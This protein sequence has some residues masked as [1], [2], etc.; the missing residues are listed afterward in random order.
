MSVFI[1]IFFLLV[2]FALLGISADYVV[3]N[4][5]Y[6]AT[7]LKIRLFAFGILLG[8]VTSLP[9]LSVG[10]NTTLDRAT[11]LSVGNLLGGMII[12][13]SLVV[14]CS[15]LLNRKVVTDG[16]LKI[17]IPQ[18]A[19]IFSPIL[20]GLDGTYGLADGLI[21]IGLYF[22]LIYYLFRANYS[23]GG[24]GFALIEK[25]KIIKAI[26]LSVVGAVGVLLLSHWIV[27]RSL[28]LSQDWGIS[29]LLL[30]VL[31]FS[32]GTNLPEISIAI[33]SWRKHISELSLSHLLSSTFTNV[34]ILGILAFIRPITIVVGPVYY[35][36]AIFLTLVLTLFLFFYR[37]GKKMDR[38]KG[39]FY[40]LATYYF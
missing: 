13:L 36:L 40:W 22:G 10:I 27:V 21:M 1:N 29:K 11:S 19:V 39:L 6:I 30:G 5:K 25:N 23:F 34:L 3:R 32:I 24:E 18:L 15:L 12:V 14:G 20:F 4:I 16:N 26:F 28:I 2:L 35:V 33:T 9:E 38:K 8:L 17:L 31:I 37:S 7:V